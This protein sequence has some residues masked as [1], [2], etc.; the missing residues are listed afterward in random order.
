MTQ[1]PLLFAGG[2]GIV[3]RQA[4][5]WFRTRHPD[6][7]LLVGGRNLATAQEAAAAC[8]HAQAVRL[9]LAHPDL[10]L[11]ATQS[12]AAMV[13]LA[14]DQAL[15]GLR[16]AQARG[17]PYLNANTGVTELGPEVAH[18]SHRPAANALVLSSHWACG[19]AL[20]LAL[21]VARPFAPVTRLD[22]GVLLD[23]EDPAGPLAWEDME[24]VH[25]AAPAALVFRDGRRDWLTGAATAGTV[26]ALDGRELAGTAFGSIDLLS[27]WVTTAAPD[28]RFDIALGESSSRRRGSAAAAEIAVGVSG[29]VAGRTTTRRA[30]LE[31][32]HG[33]ASLTALGLVLSLERV[34]GMT[35]DAPLPP[36]LYMPELLWDAGWFLQELQAAGAVLHRLP[37]S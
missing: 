10:G 3:G 5:H 37:G 7:P 36:G 9:D 27:L 8:G 34:L 16:F 30:V 35:G 13:M 20:A 24:R 19:A 1:L 2:S 21:D 12:P 31:F 18:F 29:N 28:I 11:D 26:K 15:H 22:I 32:A 4:L 33:Q 23:E 17:I 14:P 25:S 6:W